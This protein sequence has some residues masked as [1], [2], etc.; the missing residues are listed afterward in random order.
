MRLSIAWQH[1]RE[2]FEAKTGPMPVAGTRR[3]LPKNKTLLTIHVKRIVFQYNDA[4]QFGALCCML[5]TPPPSYNA[6]KICAKPKHIRS[7]RPT[8]KVASNLIKSRLFFLGP[9]WSWPPKSQ[10]TTSAFLRVSC[11]RIRCGH[12]IPGGGFRAE[13]VRVL[14][15]DYPGRDGSPFRSNRLPR[16]TSDLNRPGCCCSGRVFVFLNATLSRAEGDVGN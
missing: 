7:Y 11:S 3:P 2:V 5:P 1:G 12:S 10:R 14:R 13:R 9:V 8:Y 4:V 15:G 6:K 16:L